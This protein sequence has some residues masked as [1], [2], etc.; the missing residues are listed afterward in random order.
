MIRHTNAHDSTRAP[1]SRAMVSNN[2]AHYFTPSAISPPIVMGAN[3][4]DSTSAP[5]SPA[6]DLEYYDS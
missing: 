5:I 2:H 4:H 6:N 1:L 3:A